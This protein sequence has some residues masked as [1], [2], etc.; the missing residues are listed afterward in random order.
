V[1]CL[2]L[3]WSWTFGPL[4][5]PRLPG[6]P[7]SGIRAVVRLGGERERDPNVDQA[8]DVD[9]SHLRGRLLGNQV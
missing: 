7:N 2:S 8:S 5:L 1:W 9:D 6:L 3:L 4:P